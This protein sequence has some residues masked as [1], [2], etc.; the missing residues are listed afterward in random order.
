M[1][2]ELHMLGM[3][4]TTDF[5]SVQMGINDEVYLLAVDGEAEVWE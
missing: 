1:V 2:K 3:S 4:R 5:P